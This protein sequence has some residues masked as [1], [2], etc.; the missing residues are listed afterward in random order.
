MMQCATIKQNE[1]KVDCDL[2]DMETYLLTQQDDANRQAYQ[3]LFPRLLMP[4]LFILISSTTT[5]QS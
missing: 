2:R 5:A 4:V 1:S 3:F